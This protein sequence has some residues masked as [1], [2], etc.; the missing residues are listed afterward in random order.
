MN[1][2]FNVINFEFQT[3]PIETL[4]LAVVGPAGHPPLGRGG[5]A[6]AELRGRG[7][8]PEELGR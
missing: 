8:A 1:R 6:E 5:T 2:F 3:E 4:L 7:N